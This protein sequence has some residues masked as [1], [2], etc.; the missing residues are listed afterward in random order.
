MGEPIAPPKLAEGQQHPTQE[1]VDALHAQFYG[2]VEKLWK[3]YAATFP[4]YEK[5]K[6]V[7]E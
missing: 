5:V 1:Q 4:G 7:M 2:A 6:L 3:K